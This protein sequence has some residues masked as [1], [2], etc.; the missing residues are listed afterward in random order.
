MS[1]EI[2]IPYTPRKFQLAVHKLIEN[3]KRKSVIVAHR[4]FGKTV[5]T[6]NHLIKQAML[7]E[8]GVFGYI[9]PYRKQAKEIAWDYLKR[10]SKPIP[11]LYKNETELMIVFPTGS[12]VGLFGSDEPDALRGIHWDG[13]VIDE[14]G[15]I[16]QETWY[17][18]L[19][20]ATAVKDGFVVFIGTPKGRNLFY[21]LYL[22][23]LKNE[24][25]WNVAV[26]TINDT[27]VYTSQQIDELKRSMPEDAFSQEMFCNFGASNSNT[28]IGDDILNEAIN[29]KYSNS[30]IEQWNK[31]FG[32]DV[33]RYGND[34]T[35]ICIRQGYFLHDPIILKGKMNETVT[36]ASVIANLIREH[37]PINVFIDVGYNPGVIDVIRDLGF[38]VTEVN[39]AWNANDEYYLNKR[40]E[41]WG[42]MKEW[43]KKAQIPNNPV[44][45]DDLNSP[46]YSF[47]RG[48]LKLESKEDMRAR[49]LSS[50]DIADALALTFAFPTFLFKRNELKLVKS[51]NHS[52]DFDPYREEVFNL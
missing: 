42:N 9:A 15:Q 45:I 21:D 41:M 33:A 35:V 40:A 30:D 1:L 11:N 27:D 5:L 10:Y 26:Y 4:G 51:S 38:S 2:Q 19:Q 52:A 43:L 28:F 49:G 7:T 3:G 34:S 14:V 32:I 17:E 20:P 12:K 6:V 13:L 31:V 50:P 22:T 24:D 48:R 23:G 39:F 47:S 44:L 18:V 25:L 16:K 8:N 36:L 37:E 29:R 46:S